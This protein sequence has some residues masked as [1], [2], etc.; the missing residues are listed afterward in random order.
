LGARDQ[1]AS[2]AEYLASQAEESMGTTV[3]YPTEGAQ[4]TIETERWH[5]EGMAARNTNDGQDPSIKDREVYDAVREE[6]ASKAKA[7]AIANA[8]ARDSR[9]Q[10]GKRGGKAGSYD[11]WTVDELRARAA[12]LDVHGR[13]RMNKDDLIE[14]LRDGT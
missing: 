1:T 9:E 11:D 7:A 2:L 10:V 14:A 4:G 3:S 13:S 12:E 6:G 5:T 8:S